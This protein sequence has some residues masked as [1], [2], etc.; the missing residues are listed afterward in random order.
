MRRACADA[1]VALMVGH[2][3]RRLGAAR[4]VKELIDAGAL[5]SVVLAEANMSLPGSFKPEAW[6]AHR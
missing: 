1:G 3:F 6:R 4:R 2:A 5:G